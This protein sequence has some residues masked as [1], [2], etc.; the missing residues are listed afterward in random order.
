MNGWWVVYRCCASTLCGK[1]AAGDSEIIA[2]AAVLLEIMAGRVRRNAQSRRYEQN[3]KLKNFV[4][5]LKP[6]VRARLLELDSRTLE[7]VLGVATKQENKVESYQGENEAQKEEAPNPFQRQ[8]RKMKKL[9]E[10]QQS[11]VASGSEKPECI[12]CGKRH[13]GNACWRIE[14][15]CLRCGSKDHRLKECPNLKTKFVSRD[16]SSVIIKEQGLVWNDLGDV[17]TGT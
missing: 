13:G 6:L 11:T 7:E 8:D 12:H 4:K 9:M 15:S 1:V 5:G 2:A 17:I 3:R 10:G 16:A 14:G